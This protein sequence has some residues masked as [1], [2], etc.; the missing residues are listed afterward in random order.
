VAEGAVAAPHKGTPGGSVL[1]RRWRTSTCRFWRRRRGP[2]TVVSC[3]P[4]GL[5]CPFRRTS[6]VP[7]VVP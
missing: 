7:P 2:F 6:R 3:R 1:F 5:L 4:T